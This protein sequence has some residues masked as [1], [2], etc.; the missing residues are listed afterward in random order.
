[1]I[2]K[3]TYKRELVRMWDSIR[4]K[5][6]G[7]YS[8]YGVDCDSCP[9]ERKCDRIFSIEIIEAVE[10]WSKEH[11]KPKYKVSQL[12]YDIL[13]LLL[14]YDLKFYQSKELY[15]LLNKGYFKDA[16][17][18]TDV[19]E[20]FENCEVDCELGENKNVKR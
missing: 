5:Y 3:E 6:K 2:D 10:K 1:M 13:E 20:Y 9:L 12:E 7:E 11:P 8:C 16:T 17:G 19:K 18:E 14:K 15:G 4:D